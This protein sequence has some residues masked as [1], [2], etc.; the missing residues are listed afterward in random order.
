[1]TKGDNIQNGGSVPKP[2]NEVTRIDKPVRSIEEEDY[3]KIC[4]STL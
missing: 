2:L 4:A 1:M 3:R